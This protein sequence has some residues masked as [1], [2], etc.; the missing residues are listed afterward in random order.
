MNPMSAVPPGQG[1]PDVSAQP[2]Q[3][4]LVGPV[5]ALGSTPDPDA[6]L[7]D[8]YERA[9]RWARAHQARQRLLEQALQK[10]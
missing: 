9:A 1:V 3:R 8:R 2:P 7:C 6:E 10:G 4:V 5:S